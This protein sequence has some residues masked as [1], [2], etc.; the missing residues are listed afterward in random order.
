[1]RKKV[2][3]NCGTQAQCVISTNRGG[4]GGE[5]GEQYLDLQITHLVLCDPVNRRI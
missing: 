2:T 1:M 4:G 3:G 5:P